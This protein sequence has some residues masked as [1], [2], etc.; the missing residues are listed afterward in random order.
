[1]VGKLEFF[2]MSMIVDPKGELL[3]EMGEDG[4]E[5]ITPLD[6]QAMANWRVQIPCFNDRKP[7][8]Y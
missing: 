1:M 7:E 3:G 6:L 4:G 5:I 2:G 8:Y